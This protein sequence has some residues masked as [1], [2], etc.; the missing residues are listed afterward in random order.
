MEVRDLIEALSKLDPSTPIIKITWYDGRDED[1]CSYEELNLV[2]EL[3]ESILYRNNDGNKVV[4]EAII[5]TQPIMLIK[6]EGVNEP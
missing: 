5:L 3:Q 2:P 6:R 4:G 1:N